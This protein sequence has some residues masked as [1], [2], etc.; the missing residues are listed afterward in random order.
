MQETHWNLIEDNF[1]H[2][3]WSIFGKPDMK[4]FGDIF[5]SEI[6]EKIKEDQVWS[7]QSLALVL[8]FK[9]KLLTRYVDMLQ[10]F[11]IL[12]GIDDYVPIKETLLTKISTL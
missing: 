4:D 9:R 11:A 8:S 6:E 5:V 12:L 7:R 3:I 1:K 10:T 2:M